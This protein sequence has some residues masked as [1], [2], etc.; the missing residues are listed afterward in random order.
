MIFLIYIMAGVSLLAFLLFG[1]DK[2]LAKIGAWRIPEYVLLCAALLG[3]AVGAFVAMK[4]FRHKTCK[5]RFAT[6]V[7]LML[8]VHAV[9]LVL[10][11]CMQSPVSFF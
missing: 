1:I 2:Q 11:Y 6:G 8:V 9:L 4:M 10:L 7:P 5:C 3:G